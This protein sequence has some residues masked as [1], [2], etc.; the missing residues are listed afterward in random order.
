MK[1]GEKSLTLETNWEWKRNC[2]ESKVKSRWDNPKQSRRD[3]IEV[4]SS[5]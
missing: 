1:D 2:N 5:Y 3:S 4:N